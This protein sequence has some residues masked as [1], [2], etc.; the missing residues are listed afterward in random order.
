M[1]LFL[2]LEKTHYLTDGI[3]QIRMKKVDK[4][5]LANELKLKLFLK[6]EN[7]KLQSQKSDNIRRGSNTDKDE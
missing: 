3:F 5:T 6:N 7:S 4:R 2:Q 1:K